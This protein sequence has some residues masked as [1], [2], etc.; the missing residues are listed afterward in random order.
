MLLIIQILVRA[1]ALGA[2]AVLIA[3]GQQGPLYL[4]PPAST[5]QAP[6]PESVLPASG[7]TKTTLQPA[8][9]ASAPQNQ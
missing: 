4:P 1:L 2:S 7:S 8:T 3:C 9:A 6:P 5:Q